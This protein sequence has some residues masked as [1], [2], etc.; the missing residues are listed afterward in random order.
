MSDQMPRP[1]GSAFLYND[2]QMDWLTERWP[3]ELVKA[4]CDPFSYAVGLKSGAILLFERAYPQNAGWVHLAE[5]KVHSPS[6][7]LRQFA[8]ERGNVFQERKRG[9]I[10]R[11][12]FTRGEFLQGGDALF[13]WR[14]RVV[15]ICFAAL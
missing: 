10:I 7:A 5:V 9:R 15:G 3:G 12:N 4:C 11:G 2:E 6:P 13:E 14:M 8:F 1:E